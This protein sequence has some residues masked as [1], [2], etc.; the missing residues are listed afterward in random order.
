MGVH[1]PTSCCHP[2]MK[3]GA[4][5]MLGNLRLKM[6]LKKPQTDLLLL[7]N[8][9][10]PLSKRELFTAPDNPGQKPSNLPLK[11][12]PDSVKVNCPNI[13]CKNWPMLNNKAKPK[14]I[15]NQQVHPSTALDVLL[16]DLYYYFPIK[17]FKPTFLFF[18]V[19]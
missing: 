19:A 2:E 16:Y 9:A 3:H 13:Y 10:I 12:G 6:A 1:S 14:N 11:C 7:R 15:L 17:P 5:N 18:L 4:R 8:H